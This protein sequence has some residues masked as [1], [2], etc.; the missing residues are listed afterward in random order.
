MSNR[1]Y[2]YRLSK[3][4][5]TRNL[6]FLEKNIKEEETFKT[7]NSKSKRYIKDYHYKMV[8]LQELLCWNCGS[9]IK[10]DET[11]KRNRGLSH[12]PKYFHLKCLKYY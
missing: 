11:I 7:M 6:K 5:K 1:S 3:I 2:P 10:L 12:S 4:I 9:P 8:E